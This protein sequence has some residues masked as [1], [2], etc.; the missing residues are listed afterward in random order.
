[1]RTK[2]EAIGGNGV[3]WRLLAPLAI[4]AAHSL[5]V[6]GATAM[7]CTDPAQGGGAAPWIVI[8]ATALA[9][10]A[11]ATTLRRA[12]PGEAGTADPAAPD[13]A[14]TARDDALFLQSVLVVMSALAALAVV[15][16]AAVVFFFGPC[17]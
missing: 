10:A 17:G 12:S 8:G 2:Q 4:W 7:Q 5:A 13:G 3:L 16:V 6:F 14:W 9:L 15:Y 1:M 11:L